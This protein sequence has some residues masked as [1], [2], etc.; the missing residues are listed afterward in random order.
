MD[1]LL[2]TISFLSG[3]QDANAKGGMWGGEE[4]GG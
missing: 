1:V 4:E 2:S 3:I